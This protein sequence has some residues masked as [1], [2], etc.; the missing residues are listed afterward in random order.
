[1]KVLNLSNS[2]Y[3]TISPDFLQ[4]PPLEILTLEGCTSFIQVHESIGYLKRLVSLNLKNCTS[5]KDL[6]KNIINLEFLERLDLSACSALVRLPMS[7][8]S[9]LELKNTKVFRNLKT[10]SLSGCSRLTKLPNFLPSPQLESLVLESCTGL[11]E[12]HESIGLLKRLVLLDLQRYENLSNLPKTISNLESLKTLNLFGCIRLDELPKE[13]GNV[14]ALMELYAGKIAIKQLPSSFS[15]SKNLEFVTFLECE[16]LIESAEFS[17]AS[18]LKT[19]ILTGCN[20]L[21]KVHDSIKHL[22]RLSHMSLMGCENFTNLPS[23]ICNL[24]SLRI[25]VLTGCFKLDELPEELGRI[26]KFLK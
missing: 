26:I 13:L 18:R 15:L 6:P 1:L 3:L 25:L 19:L 21:V 12:I 20:R 9:P 7:P 10:V 17:K 24:E 22:K 5:L 23:S 2:K 4:V 8:M 14:T 16:Y 11:E